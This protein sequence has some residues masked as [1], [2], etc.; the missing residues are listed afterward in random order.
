MACWLLE[1][2][3]VEVGS[4]LN[5]DCVDST[6]LASELV[7]G[8]VVGAEVAKALYD[9]VDILFNEESSLLEEDNEFFSYFVKSL[10][11]SD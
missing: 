3:I 7:I 9:D 5:A 2:A 4:T 6:L 8:D 1:E 10:N 11:T